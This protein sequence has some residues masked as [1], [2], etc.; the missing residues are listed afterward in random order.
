MTFFWQI[1]IHLLDKSTP[2]NIFKSPDGEVI[3]F[4][5]Y[6]PLF[7]TTVGNILAILVYCFFFLAGFVDKDSSG[8]D[9]SFRG[10]KHVCTLAYR[11]QNGF[12]NVP[13]EDCIH[14]LFTFQE[15]LFSCIPARSVLRWMGPIIRLATTECL[16]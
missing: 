2:P 6:H 15:K 16:R 12:S 11:L 13:K 14:L 5:V 3:A 9:Y 8:N 10:M 7:G 4:K 1:H